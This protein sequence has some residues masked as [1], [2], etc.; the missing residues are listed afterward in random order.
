MRCAKACRPCRSRQ[1]LSNEHLLAKIG[2]DTNENEPSKVWPAC[3]QPAP[4]LP[5][6]EQPYATQVVG[7]GVGDTTVATAVSAGCAYVVIAVLLIANPAL[8]ALVAKSLTTAAKLLLEAAA[9]CKVVLSVVASATVMVFCTCA[10][11]VNVVV[12]IES[13]RGNA[14][15]A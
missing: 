8:S 2:V 14:L 9:V 1:Q 3:L 7:A 4:D 12:L 5:S 11:T 15:P 10:S 13:R 6:N